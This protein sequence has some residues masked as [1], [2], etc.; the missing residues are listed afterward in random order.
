MHFFFK[1]GVYK[2]SD[3]SRALKARRECH[4]E[5]E[6]QQ[7]GTGTAKT[8]ATLLRTSRKRHRAGPKDKEGRAGTG[9]PQEEHT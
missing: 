9:K 6:G 7:L 1:C 2:G 3:S 5:K 4:N 8:W